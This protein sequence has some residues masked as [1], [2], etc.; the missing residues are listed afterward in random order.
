MKTGTQPLIHEQF[1]KEQLMIC[2]NVKNRKALFSLTDM[3]L[4]LYKQKWLHDVFLFISFQPQFQC[5][6]MKI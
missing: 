2:I 1:L 5:V 6:S 3:F 4:L